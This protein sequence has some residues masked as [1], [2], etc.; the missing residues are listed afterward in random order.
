MEE[1]TPQQN[2]SRPIAIEQSAKDRALEL[3]IVSGVA[4]V[5]SGW[6][7][8]HTAKNITNVSSDV[9]QVTVLV[10]RLLNWWLS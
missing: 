9:I 8:R 4:E 7:A 5:P 3:A 6:D 1:S 2:P 10:D